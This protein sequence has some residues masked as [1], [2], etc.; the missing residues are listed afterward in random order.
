MQR[1]V[2]DY[3]EWKIIEFSRLR[4]ESKRQRAKNVASLRDAETKR[5][6]DNRE[7]KTTKKY[8]ARIRSRLSV[9]SVIPVLSL[10]SLSSLPPLC[11][12]SVLSVRH[13]EAWHK[14][15]QS[16]PKRA[17]EEIP[18]VAKAPSE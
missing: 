4:K 11:S 7:K 2:G 5:R 10:S 1:G 8:D 6:R 17:N 18:T 14:P 16:H 15:W 13:C 12:L 9:L 3:Q